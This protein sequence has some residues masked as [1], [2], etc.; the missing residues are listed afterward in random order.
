MERN[1]CDEI[2]EKTRRL[3][4]INDIMEFG[5]MNYPNI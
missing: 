1:K 2:N 5:V 3:D 4:E